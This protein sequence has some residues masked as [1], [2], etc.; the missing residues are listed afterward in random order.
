MK[1]TLTAFALTALMAGP[2]SAQSGEEAPSGGFNLVEEGAR[3]IMRGLMEE[4]SPTIDSL[5][6][7][8]EEMGPVVGDFLREMG[9][10]LATFLN[11]VDDV[12]HYELPEF[13]PNG[14]IIL[15]RKPDAPLFVPDLDTDGGEIEL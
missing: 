1:A 4:M 9:P 13:L 3:M 10:G 5:R 2:A 14:D 6:D 15:R 11:R 7:T 8:L 12:R